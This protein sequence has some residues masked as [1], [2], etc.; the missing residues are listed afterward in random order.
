MRVRRKDSGGTSLFEFLDDAKLEPPLAEEGLKT[1]GVYYIVGEI[2]EG[3]LTEIQQDILLKHLNPHW[4][5]DV[6]I[7]VNSVGGQIAEGSA[8][9]SMMKHVRMDVK[10]VAVGEVCS[11]GACILAAGTVGKRLADSDA[12]IMVHGFY[13]DFMGG[14]RDQILSQL[15]WVEQEYNREIKFWTQHSVFE[16]E[17]EV[18]EYLLNGNDIYLTAEGALEYGIIDGILKPAKKQK[19]IR[20]RRKKTT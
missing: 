6:Q 11:M 4:K 18:K 17:K 9:I 3:S 20:K 7:V 19:K 1:Q 13:T 12:T 15:K 5:D 16:T 10:T 14:T 8:L 2:D